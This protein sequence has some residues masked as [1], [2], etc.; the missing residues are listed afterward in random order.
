[1]T[2][3]LVAPA[4]GMAVRQLMQ[5]AQN[6]ANPMTVVKHGRREDRAVAYDRFIQACNRAVRDREKHDGIGEVWSTWQS[7]NL[8]ADKTVRAAAEKLVDRVLAIAD[9]GAMGEW[10]RWV[11]DTEREPDLTRE[12][13][14]REFG[15]DLSQDEE[16]LFHRATRDFI[17]VAR[18]DLL[19]RF[20]HGPIPARLRNWILDRK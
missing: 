14:E 12:D 13:V 16:V 3:P 20:W 18:R 5:L 2:D 17:Q 7:I 9:P 19:R 15:R 10:R 11:F 1:M 6:A 4:S 8:R